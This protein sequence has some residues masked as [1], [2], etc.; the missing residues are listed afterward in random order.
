VISSDQPKGTEASENGLVAYSSSLAVSA[1]M[2]TFA[3]NLIVN[4][5]RRKTTPQGCDAFG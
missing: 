2:Q 1:D 5:F 3:S 4:P